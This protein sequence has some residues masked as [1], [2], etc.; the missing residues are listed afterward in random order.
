MDDQTPRSDETKPG[1]TWQR[2]TLYALLLVA[3]GF[4]ALTVLGD[5]K[6]DTGEDDLSLLSSAA[7]LTWLASWALAIA[8][9]AMGVMTIVRNRSK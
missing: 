8:A 2:W 9:A 5:G 6:T 3:L 1:V 4:G 7:F